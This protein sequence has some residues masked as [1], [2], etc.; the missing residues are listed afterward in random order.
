[1]DLYRTQQHQTR[2]PHWKIEESLNNAHTVKDRL[3]LG[4]PGVG[5]RN[6]LMGYLRRTYG[7]WSADTVQAVARAVH[8]HRDM[9][10]PDMVRNT[11]DLVTRLR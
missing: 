1:M 8:G 9:A 7:S 11:G 2:T 3:T 4:L 10:T 6:D 5:R